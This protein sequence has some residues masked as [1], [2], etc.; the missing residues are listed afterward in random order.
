MYRCY[1][2]RGGHIVSGEDLDV[3]TLE[4]ATTEGFRLLDVCPDNG[5]GQPDG[6][7]IWQGA[8]LLY[9]AIGS[10]DTTA[11]RGFEPDLAE[12]G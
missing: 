5:D 3:R 12:H 4:D 10:A 6:I 2:T 9:E 11:I 8:S 7:E 1:L